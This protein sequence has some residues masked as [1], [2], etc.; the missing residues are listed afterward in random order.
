MFY[1]ALVN[2]FFTVFFLFVSPLLPVRKRRE[3]C[4][5][6]C[7][8]LSACLASTPWNQ[9]ALC[10]VAG[11]FKLQLTLWLQVDPTHHTQMPTGIRTYIGICMC[12][13]CIILVKLWMPYV[14][15]ARNVLWPEHFFIIIG[16]RLRL[17]N[18]HKTQLPGVL[19]SLS[20]VVLS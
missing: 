8:S 20:I 10:S 4:L 9:F 19:F 13:F 17:T 15:L 3:I 14:L 6:N 7:S 12:V 5:S 2:I 18:L 1:L 16:I 11:R